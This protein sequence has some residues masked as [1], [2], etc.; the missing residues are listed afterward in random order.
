MSGT[1]TTLHVFAG[2]NDGA[3]P[4]AGLTEL[5]GVFYGTTT[6]GGGTGCGGDGCGTIFSVTPGGAYNVIYSFQG[7]SDGQRPAAQL[8]VWH[9]AL[10]GTTVYGGG[11]GCS[12]GG[13]AGCGTVFRLKP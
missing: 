2:G 10:Y 6:A 9:G 5:R 1:E 4:A 11:T 12:G 3:S 7:G 13:Y 8:L